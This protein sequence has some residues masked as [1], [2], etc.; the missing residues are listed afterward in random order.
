MKEQNGGNDTHR[1]LKSFAK[2]GASL[3]IICY[4]AKDVF[5]PSINRYAFYLATGLCIVVVGIILFL[6]VDRQ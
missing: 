1:I 3:A 2:A 4:L 6:W 5:P